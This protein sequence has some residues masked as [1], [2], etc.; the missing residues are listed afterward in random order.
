MPRPV[1]VSVFVGLSA[2]VMGEQPAT[3]TPAAAPIDAEV[4]E[5]VQLRH[6][7]WYYGRVGDWSTAGRVVDEP[8]VA[9]MVGGDKSAPVSIRWEGPGSGLILEGPE[10]YRSWQPRA[11]PTRMYRHAAWQ[12]QGGDARVHRTWWSFYEALETA[13]HQRGLLVLIPGMLATPEPVLEAIVTGL[14]GRGW[15]VMRMLAHPSIYTEDAGIDALM[16]TP[17]EVA[18]RFAIEADKRFAALVQTVHAALDAAAAVEGPR[19]LISMSGG[20][21]A[22]PA[23]LASLSRDQGEVPG[24]AGFAACVM[25]GAG[26][27]V[28]SMSESSAYAGF[29]GGLQLDWGEIGRDDARLAD[30]VAAYRARPSLDPYHTAEQ[31]RQVKVLLVQGARDRAVPARLGAIMWNKLGQPERW[32]APVGHELLFFGYLPS[33]SRDLLDWIDASVSVS[34]GQAFPAG[35]DGP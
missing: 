23:L 10:G 22:T 32:L 3:I 1:I 14:R 33:R 24:Q 7:G 2:L 25:I 15:A 13:D 9:R 34:T 18:E 30:I 35:W 20:T 17:A 31:V 6:D 28:L 16:G 12:I 27:D 5:E 8:L 11:E 26:A 21:L 4:F 19:V 29:L